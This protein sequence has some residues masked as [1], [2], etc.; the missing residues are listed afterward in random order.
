MQDDVKAARKREIEEACLDLLA[1]HGFE[2][3][4]MLAVA[5]R[6]KASNETLYSW[7]GDKVGLYAALVN[8]N[9]Q[10]SAAILEAALAGVDEPVSALRRLGP[11]LLAMVTGERAIAL[12]RAAAADA[13]GTLGR[14][15]SEGGRSRI[16]PLLCATLE[17]VAHEG[18][19]GTMEPIEA[20]ELYV[21]LLIGD[22]QIRRAI[23]ALPPL[24]DEAIARRSA[25][26]LSRLLLLCEAPPP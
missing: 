9:A 15:M 10:E 17:R 14:I 25:D 19:L 7:Y 23:G 6:A 3:T 20:A 18:R 24:T 5:R 2:K 11:V 21:S 16:L 4:S 13:T 26:A 1:A 22:L 12:N 8:R